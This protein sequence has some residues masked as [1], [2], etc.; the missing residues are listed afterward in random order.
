MD[1][2]E[3]FSVSGSRLVDQHGRTLMLRGANVGG[4]SKVPRAPNGATHIREGFLDHR[5]VSFVGRP[6]PLGE[7]DEH[8]ARLREWGM[9]FLRLVVTWEAVEHPGPGIV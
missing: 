6:F 2:V 4:S 8:F 5:L 9:T 1:A 3:R 7:A